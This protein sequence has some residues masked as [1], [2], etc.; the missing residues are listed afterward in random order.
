MQ[1]GSPDRLTSPLSRRRFLIGLGSAAAAAAFLAAC[2]E[3]AGEATAGAS[4]TVSRTGTSEAPA[5]SSAGSSGTSTA[6]GGAAATEAAAAFPVTLSHKFG[7]TE[8]AAEPGRVV[9]IG[10]SDHDAIL[11]AGVTPVATRYW[12]GEEPGAVFPWAQAYLAGETPEVLQMAELDFEQIAALRPDVIIAVYSG[13]TAEDYATLSQ[14]APVVAQSPD[15]IDYGMPWDEAARLIASALGRSEQMAEVIAGIESKYAAA[16]A[17]HPDFAGK[18]LVLAAMRADGAVGVFAEQDQRMRFFTN[19]GFELPAELDGLFGESFYANI[20]PE[21]F[22]LLDS[23]DVVAWTQVVYA[24]RDAILENP[25]YGQ[26]AVAKES[27]HV[28]IDGYA[29]AA[30]SFNSVLSQGYALDAVVPALAAA[31]DGDPAT[32]VE[33]PAA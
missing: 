25:V 6:A 10:Y 13:I 20:S 4:G 19:L 8:I 28:L 31:I 15:Y 9:S 21:Q 3:D 18:Q 33:I 22:H 26:L 30:F 32:N 23:G 27:R 16:R 12:F 5:T 7:T 29:D 1:S 11:A 17:A 2:S 24:G 14:I